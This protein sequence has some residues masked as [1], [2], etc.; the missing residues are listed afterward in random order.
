MNSVV[1]SPLINF[2][3]IT[4]I[5]IELRFDYECAGKDEKYEV[6]LLRFRVNGLSD[7]NNRQNNKRIGL[8]NL[9]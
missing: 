3:F 8:R 4:I 9:R 5:N 1:A 2:V 6:V 7:E